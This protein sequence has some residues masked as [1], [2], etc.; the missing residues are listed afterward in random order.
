[1]G[2]SQ[3][4]ATPG[5]VIANAGVL[6]S[7]AGLQFSKDF[8]VL[9][10]RPMQRLLRSRFSPVFRPMRYVPLPGQE[11]RADGDVWIAI[12]VL[13]LYLALY[14]FVQLPGKPLPTLSSRSPA[15]VSSVRLFPLA[16]SSPEQDKD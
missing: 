14:R 10:L 4:A 1:M 6:I 5:S 7:G 9:I 3:D 15:S 16:P 8:F 11:A 12:P 2:I 13:I